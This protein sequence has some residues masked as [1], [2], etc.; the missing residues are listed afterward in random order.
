MKGCSI[1][2]C[3][4]LLKGWVLIGDTGMS[5]RSPKQT[6]TIPA[7]VNYLCVFLS[8]TKRPINELVASICFVDRPSADT[9]PK[10]IRSLSLYIYIYT[11]CAYARTLYL[12][13]IVN[14][15]FQSFPGLRCLVEA[16]C[17]GV[18]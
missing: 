11:V 4:F 14:I 8:Q 13:A 5:E 7:Q 16:I 1:H 15:V 12:R 10:R 6:A 3:Q 9:D 2:V 17:W 18:K